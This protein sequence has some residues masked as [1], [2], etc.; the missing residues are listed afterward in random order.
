MKVLINTESLVPP[1]TG[2]GNYTYHLLQ[3]LS[4]LPQ[5]AAVECFNARR[6]SSAQDAL[7]DCDTALTQPQAR[8]TGGLRSRFSRLPMA[9]QLREVLRNAQLRFNARHYKDFIYHEPNIILKAHPGPSVAT[10]HDLSFVHHPHMHPPARVA[11]LTQQ[12]PKTLA[13]A[14]F[15]ITDSETVRQELIED[16]AVAPDRVRS[17]YLGADARFKPHTAEQSASVL[18]RH[19]LHHG[20]YVLFVGTLEP[21]KGVDLLIDAWCSMPEPLRRDMPLVLAGAPGWHG[22][23]LNARIASLGVTHG[24]RHLKFVPAADLPA[25]Y[26]GAGLFCYPSLYEGF[27]LPVLEA[28]SSGV[29][30]LCSAD[31]CMAEFSTGSTALFE[32]G[33]REHLAER[34]QALLIDP[35]QRQ[36][37][38]ANGLKRAAD[39]SWQRCAEQTAEIYRLVAG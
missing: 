18:Q 26:A 12:L 1:L 13:R 30:V 14:D 8:S 38:A 3:E 5:L 33:S 35:G 17:V 36:A 37:L 2:I 7:H 19:G 27:G 31:T 21:R 11:W 32:R 6:F 28:M 39:F 34:L 25:L 29:P 23:E 4:R 10:I 22:E 16:F 15:L 20:G 9:Y 24:L